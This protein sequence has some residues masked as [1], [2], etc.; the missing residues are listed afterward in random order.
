MLLRDSY[1]FD[2]MVKLARL[3]MM[4]EK[5]DAYTVNGLFLSKLLG[6]QTKRRISQIRILD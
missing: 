5:F 3:A 2:S 4:L 1:H 6:V